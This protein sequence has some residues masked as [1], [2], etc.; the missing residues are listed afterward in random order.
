[1]ETV[2]AVD[3]DGTI[4]DFA[5]PNIGNDNPGAIKWMKRW[6]DEGAKIILYTIRD[7]KELQDAVNYLNSNNI[8]L[9][10]INNNPDQESWNKSKKI[11]AN[12]YI[13]DAA[14][15]C[16]LNYRSCFNKESVNWSIVGPKA[17]NFIKARNNR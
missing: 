3:F 12:L 4:V 8:P 16:P 11:F 9:Y 14:F 5:Y 2:I 17:L 6:I 15:G 1:M 13:D 10:G 7:G